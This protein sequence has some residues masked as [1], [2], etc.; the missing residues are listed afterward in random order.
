M[1]K[2]QKDNLFVL[3]KS[4]SKSEKRQFKLYVGRLGVNEDSKFLLLF[5]IL[6]K[7]AEY[8]EQIILKKGIVKKQ[9]LSNLKAH[10][11]KQVLISLRLNPLHQNIRVQIREQ[12]DFATILY[13]KGLYKQSL[14][15][16]DKAKTL[17]LNYEEKN[18]AY[19]ILE[20]EKIIESQYITRSIS[21]RAD[22]LTIQ[23]KE[24]NAQN[25]LASKL[26]NLALQLYGLFLKTGY[27]KNDKE[28]KRV[29]KYF[30]DRLPKYD[31]KNLGFREKLWLYQSYLWYSFLVQDFLACYRYSRKWVDLFYEYP[32]MM[33]LNPVFFL[34]GN[35]YLLEA[36]FFIRHHDKFKDALIKL[37]TI[38][39]EKEFPKN[40][41]VESLTFL[42]VY[43]NKLNLHFMEGSFHEGL[44]LI[45]EVL[46]GIKK[47]KSRIDEHHIMV[48]YYKIASLYFG[49]GENK[50]CIEYLEKIISNKS[51]SMREDLLCFSR[52]LNLV[53]HYE[54]GLDY[55]LDALIRSTY[56]FLIRMEDLYEV[57]K[58][59]IKFL[60]VL[61]D[62]YPN[63]IRAEF[64]KLHEKLKTYEDHPYESRAF[65]YLDIISWLESKIENKSVDLI[66][67]EKF[68]AKN[69]IN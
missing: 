63:E 27:V 54:A 67:R 25:I 34:R 44:P 31:I 15:I 9:Q 47:H 19:E 50:K 36:L 12:L 14:K 8:D 10:L 7:M 52:V 38:T 41:N 42:Y 53:A 60:R 20:L 32:E 59:M 30:N 11:Y 5:N 66:I 64:I 2:E 33:K 43:S 28:F 48:F 4:L 45:D 46:K 13:H 65:L 39:K 58:E 29:T 26:S 69:K 17:A 35:Q 40:D 68:K 22:E 18:I 56:K 61:G 3:V 55:N 51:L 6:D 23:A 21:N 16:L 62:I 37:E 57:Q 49:I 1:T 24:L